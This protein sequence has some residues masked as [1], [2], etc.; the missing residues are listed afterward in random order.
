MRHETM[1]LQTFDLGRGG[2]GAE[3]LTDEGTSV[4]TEDRETEGLRDE[5]T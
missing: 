4:A 3:V 5:A 2:E 1:D